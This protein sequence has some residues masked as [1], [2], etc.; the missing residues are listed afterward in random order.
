MG[1]T[2]S[3]HGGSSGPTSLLK[4]G[5]PRAQDKRK[6]HFS[7]PCAQTSPKLLSRRLTSVKKAK[8]YPQFFLTN[9]EWFCKGEVSTFQENIA[10]SSTHQRHSALRHLTHTQHSPFMNSPNMRLS[11]SRTIQYFRFSVQDVITCHSKPRLQY[12]GPN[13]Q[14][15]WPRAAYTLCKLQALCKCPQFLT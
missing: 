12:Y 11:S 10:L 7:S 13:I 5:H 15:D 4:Q 2:G 6:G 8:L 1:Q 14:L 9:R 3:N